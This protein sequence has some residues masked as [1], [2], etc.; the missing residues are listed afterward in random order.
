MTAIT[1]YALFADDFRILAF[2]KGADR[3]FDV[4]TSFGII[5]FSIEIVLTCKATQNYFC[6]FFFWLDIVST[7]SMVF[8]ISVIFSLIDT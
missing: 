8:D 6:S 4:L 1:V 5:M 3:Y 2:P 7:I